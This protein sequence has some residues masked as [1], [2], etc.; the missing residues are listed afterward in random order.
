MECF[1]TNQLSH[2]SQKAKYAFASLVIVLG[3]CFV[4]ILV[5]KHFWNEYTSLVF[6]YKYQQNITVGWPVVVNTWSWWLGIAIVIVLPFMYFMQDWKMPAAALTS[7]GLFIN[8]QLMRNTMIVFSNIKSI[9]KEPDGFSIEIADADDIIKQQVFL[10]KP[11]VKS[12]LAQ[13]RIFLTAD[14][15]TG[16][17]ENFRVDLSNKLNILKL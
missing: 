12:N 9:Q 6:S 4:G 5:S 16:D 10:F 11:F 13:N 2:N 8:Q 3:L 15:C 14:Y 7:G 1:F 17:I